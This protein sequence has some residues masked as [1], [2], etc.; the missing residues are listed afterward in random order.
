MKNKTIC[1][2]SGS[3][4]DYNEN[5]WILHEMSKHKDLHVVSI[6]IQGANVY[7]TPGEWKQE[8][9][10]IE[11]DT[12][13]QYAG[14][15]ISKFGDGLSANKID[16]V[17]LLGDRWEIL[18]VA[19]AAKIHRIPII[20]LHGGEE[21]EGSYDNDFRHCISQLSAIHFVINGYCKE[22]LHSKGIYGN[23]HV[24]GSPRDDHK[25]NIELTT[26][27][28][29]D[30]GLS[31]DRKTAL[32]IYHP[33]TKHNDIDDCAKK[34]F[35]ALG[36]IDMQYVIIF[37]N[38]D[39]GSEY[40]D[41]QII[42]FRNEGVIKCGVLDYQKYLS[43]LSAVDIMIG[44]SS[45]GIQETPSFKKPCVNVGD[46]QKGREQSGNVINATYDN[47]K[48]KVRYGLSDEFRDKM[49]CMPFGDG[50]VS[51]RIVEIIRRVIK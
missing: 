2:I 5:Y 49:F 39:Q 28:L 32:V 20:H 18:Q 50:R 4:S 45:A 46:R 31:K 35:K 13:C 41:R 51:E 40:I 30:M 48:E 11:G 44:N 23:I 8:S 43:V 27:I 22:R 16:Y 19:I 24:V 38:F 42:N 15:C 3:R 14:E 47:I 7:P 1:V 36:E 33:E 10:F 26:D 6:D 12:V 9:M 17:F 21:T 29:Q 25:N 37:P 34:F